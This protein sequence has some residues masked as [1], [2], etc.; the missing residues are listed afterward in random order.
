MPT[1]TDAA[2]Q[3]KV[4][5]E[6]ESLIEWKN[7]YESK[8]NDL[9]AAGDGEA[10]AVAFVTLTGLIESLDVEADKV[11]PT[12]SGIFIAKACFL[13]DQVNRLDA[14]DGELKVLR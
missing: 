5:K 13:A 4:T 7:R 14:F 1:N 3:R 12:E 10:I 11:E 8:V 9:L 2:P 6:A